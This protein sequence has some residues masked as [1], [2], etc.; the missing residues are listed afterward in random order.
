MSHSATPGS[1]TPRSIAWAGLILAVLSFALGARAYIHDR[2]ERPADGV[3][4]SLQMFHLHFHPLKPKKAQTGTV[5][6]TPTP[7]DEHAMDH[8]EDGDVPLSLEIA[9][10]SQRRHAA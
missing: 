9:R 2:P 4:K 8:G 1:S 6:A 10:Y 5:P 3:F 7:A